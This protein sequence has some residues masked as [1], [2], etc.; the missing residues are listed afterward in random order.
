MSIC[1]T[2]IPQ[3]KKIRPT[4]R[5][6]NKKNPS[7]LLIP[8]QKKSVRPLDTTQ[9]TLN[10][11]ISL[12]KNTAR[13][14][15]PTIP[16]RKYLIG[17]RSDSLKC[18][19]SSQPIPYHSMRNQ[20][21]HRNWTFAQIS[22]QHTPH[23][24]I[25]R[26]ALHNLSRSHRRIVYIPRAIHLSEIYTIPVTLVHSLHHDEFG[27]HVHDPDPAFWLTVQTAP[28][29]LV[30]TPVDWDVEFS[31][32]SLFGF[33]RWCNV[34]SLDQHSHEIYGYFVWVDNIKHLVAVVEFIGGEPRDELVRDITVTNEAFAEVED[35]RVQRRGGDIARHRERYF[36]GYVNGICL[37]ICEINCV[38]DLWNKLRWTFVK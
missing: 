26:I 23:T 6:H 19:S 15:P 8:Q 13:T 1:P 36:V 28:I 14:R 32:G 20:R 27:V 4:S 3:Q 21:L 2:S 25:I 24:G 38:G 17:S 30:R 31:R 33:D 18:H 7:N 34:E 10:P 29:L 5:Y 9:Q 16:E 12:S 35:L 37:W 22:I 11:I